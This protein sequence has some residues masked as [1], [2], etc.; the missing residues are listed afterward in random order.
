MMSKNA[1]NEMT[2]GKILKIILFF[3][4]PLLVGN[5]F[6]QLYSMV[7]TIIVGNYL[8]ENALAAVGTT[9]PISFLVIGFAQG[10]SS[11]L[12]VITSQRFGA[13]DESGVRKS[14][15]TSIILCLLTSLILT[16]LSVSFIDPL[17]HL[18]NVPEAIFND[19]KI[20]IVL[21]FLGIIAT[22]FYNLISSILRAIGDSKTPLY[23]L[24]FSSLIN[25]L[26]DILFIG[27]LKM[28]I[29]GAAYATIIAQAL[30]AICCFIYTFIRYPHLRLSKEDFKL[31][32]SSCFSHLKISLPM[33]LQFSVTAI[34]TI[35]LQSFLNKLGTSAIAGFTAA[36]KIEVLLVQPL[37]TLGMTMA[38]FCGQNYGANEMTRVKKG[39]K[40]A[41]LICLICSLLAAILNLTLGRAFINLFVNNP[42]PE[43]IEY[44]QTYLNVI[45][46]FYPFLGILFIFRNSLQAIG[47][48][49]IP[50]L[51]GISELVARVLI[52]VT[53]PQHIGYLGICFASPLAW[54]LASMLVMIKMITLIHKRTT[55]YSNPCLVQNH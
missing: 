42:T 9:G 32:A 19:A 38:V 8:G 46:L 14:F 7:D 11:G 4:L 3:S 12:S 24:I 47:S 35:T 37:N 6:Q 21:I 54:V 25:V 45:A 22:I 34:G 20:Y 13:K 50:M 27:P 2:T 41:V 16:L 33:A 40:D 55:T 29:A 52:A 49:F 1:Q 23:F 48:N 44:S 39:L 18:M 10:M 5:I 17:L 28:G 26:L 51:G 53:L 15:A 43:V 30:S 36:N 31:S